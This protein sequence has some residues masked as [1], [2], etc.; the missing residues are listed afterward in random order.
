MDNTPSN[1]RRRFSRTLFDG[2][3]S[4]QTAEQTV[5][6]RVIDISLKGALVEYGSDW[7][8]QKGDEALLRISL[9]GGDTEIRMKTQVA[10]IE[11][12][13]L[14]LYCREI[15]MDSIAH[16]RRLMELNLGDEALLERELGAL[17]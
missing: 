6:T 4:L 8:L 16:L 7:Q 12:G 1:D 9:A 14:G 3:A 5:V 10:H 15:D 2:S 13:Q 11:N 17:G